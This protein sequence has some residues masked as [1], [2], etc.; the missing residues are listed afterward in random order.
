MCYRIR[1]ADTQKSATIVI[2]PKIVL[3]IICSCIFGVFSVV[4]Q[5]QIHICFS[6]M[7]KMK[8]KERDE[9]TPG[10]YDFN[11]LNNRMSSLFHGIPQV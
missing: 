7:K 1:A 6:R 4:V 10:F 8:P 3:S 2:I 5:H 9:F 11:L